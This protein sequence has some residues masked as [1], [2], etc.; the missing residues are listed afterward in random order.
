MTWTAKNLDS[1]NTQGC[2]PHEEIDLFF[3]VFWEEGGIRPVVTMTYKKNE[4][5][6]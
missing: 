2:Y 1:I 4:H 6:S 3:F 5:V